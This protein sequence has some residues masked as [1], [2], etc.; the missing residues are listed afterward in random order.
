V[1]KDGHAEFRKVETG[2]TGAT[3]IESLKGLNDGE[4]II[5]GSY[6]A[7]RTLRNQARLKVD[8][9]APVLAQGQ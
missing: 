9:R 5:I 6:K 1:V 3:D 8:N 7:I 2:I 4:E